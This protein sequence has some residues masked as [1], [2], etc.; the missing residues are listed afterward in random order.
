MKIQQARSIYQFQAIN[1]VPGPIIDFTEQDAE[2]VDFSHNDALVISVKLAYA[3]VDRIMVDNDSSVNILQLSVI[4]NMGLESTIQRKEKVLTGFNR[5]TLTTSGT[6]TLK[7]TSP[8]IVSSQTF[9]IV[10][11]PSPHNGILGRTW[12]VKIGTVTSIE[13]QKI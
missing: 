7:V 6:I 4:Q 5:L 13:Y 2:G 10:S 1:V 3:I 9:M 8:P 12:L 11:V